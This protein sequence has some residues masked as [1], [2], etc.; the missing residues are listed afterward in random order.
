MPAVQ[1]QP[2]IPE[3]HVRPLHGR[4]G[5]TVSDLLLPSVSGM[6]GKRVVEGFAID[7]L[8]VLRQMA[9]NWQ[10]KVG[11]RLIGHEW[12]RAKPALRTLPWNG[13]IVRGLL[14]GSLQ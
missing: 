14:P 13:Q 4:P 10:G 9:A 2:V 11:I 12:A 3:L 5:F 8:R 6:R 7:I 1:G